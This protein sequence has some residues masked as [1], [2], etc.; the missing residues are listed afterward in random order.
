MSDNT[1]TQEKAAPEADVRL[2]W[3]PPER[4]EWVQRINEEGDCM[5]IE[6]IVPLDEQSLLNSAMESTGPRPTSARTIGASPS[7]SSSRR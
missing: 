4:P 7:R 2:E 1:A 3:Q 5:E 6:Q